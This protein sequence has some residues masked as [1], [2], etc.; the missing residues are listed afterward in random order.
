[1]FT[2]LATVGYRV[3]KADAFTAFHRFQKQIGSVTMSDPHLKLDMITLSPSQPNYGSSTG[4][5]VCHGTTIVPVL[6]KGSNGKAFLMTIEECRNH[7]KTIVKRRLPQPSEF[8]IEGR[9]VDLAKVRLVNPDLTVYT[10][11]NTSE[12]ERLSHHGLVTPHPCTYQTKLTV[13]SIDSH[14]AQVLCYQ[15]QA[16]AVSNTQ[17]DL[18]DYV[19]NSIYGVNYLA[20][21]LCGAVGLGVDWYA[22][23]MLFEN[24]Q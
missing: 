16:V 3:W 7:Q 14:H 18:V 6:P 4:H 5:V 12:K 13:Q 20:W 24:G 19:R 15:G 2:A 21:I 17:A 23:R 1:M 22:Y 8:E 9:T 10:I 11:E